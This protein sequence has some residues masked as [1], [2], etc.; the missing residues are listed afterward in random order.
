MADLKAGL[1]IPSGLRGQVSAGFSWSQDCSQAFT[2]LWVAAST[3]GLSCRLSNTMS[4]VSSIVSASPCG[5]LWLMEDGKSAFWEELT[6]L[7]LRRFGFSFVPH[8][9]APGAGH[10]PGRAVL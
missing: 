8:P 4:F 6:K 1:A 5:V 9:A 10:Q 7:S 3:A 2:A